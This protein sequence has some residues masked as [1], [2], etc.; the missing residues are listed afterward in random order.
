[1]RRRFLLLLI[2]VLGALAASGCKNHPLRGERPFASWGHKEIAAASEV[3][4]PDRAAAP[5]E[6]KGT[7]PASSETQPVPAATP[8]AGQPTTPA[9]PTGLPKPPRFDALP[10]PAFPGDG[11]G[12]AKALVYEEISSAPAKAPAQAAPRANAAPQNESAPAG[13]EIITILPRRDQA[14]PN[15]KRLPI[16]EARATSTLSGEVQQF[17]H[18]WR[19]RYAPPDADDPHGGSVCLEGAGLEHLQDGQRVRVTGAQLPATDRFTGPRFQVQILEV[20]QP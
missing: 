1:M 9:T 4:D 12:G 17:R 15:T 20:L 14:E 13:P 8:N 10:P 18:V 11:P 7:D 6:V 5:A 3:P 16:G 19:L 2:G